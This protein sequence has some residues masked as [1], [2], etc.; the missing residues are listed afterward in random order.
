MV[1]HKVVRINSIS[2]FVYDE[3]KTPDISDFT[4]TTSWLKQ[5]ALLVFS[6]NNGESYE[7]ARSIKKSL[8]IPSITV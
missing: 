4:N 1:N 7:K 5:G 8:N 6:P 2:T 3:N